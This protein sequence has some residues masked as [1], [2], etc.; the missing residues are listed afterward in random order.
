MTALATPPTSTVAQEFALLVRYCARVTDPRKAR[1]KVHPLPA[2][3]ALGLLGLMAGQPSIKDVVRW[4]ERHPELWPALGLRRCPS[5]ATLWRLLQQVS[6][7][8][9]HTLLRDF[10][11]H[12]ATLRQPQEPTAGWH[13]VALDGKTLRGTREETQP[14]RVLHAFATEGA[15]L[16]D[17]LPLSSH[18]AEA[19]EA[20]AWVAALG[21]RF[22]GLQVLTGDAAYAEQSLCAAIVGAQREYLVRVKKTSP[23]SGAT[24]RNSLPTPPHPGCSPRSGR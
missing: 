15:L 12:L 10:T 24:S 3:L 18:G 22:P 4:A 7:A 19:A 20:Q 11:A 21:E 17:T 14:L 6:V 9:I 16:L 8:E 13:T 23:R 5:V 2:L 1:G